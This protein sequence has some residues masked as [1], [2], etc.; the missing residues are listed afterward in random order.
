ML[1]G[2]SGEVIW[3][4]CEL[5]HSGKEMQRGPILNGLPAWYLENQLAKFQAGIR[6]NS[7]ENRSAAL[8]AAA[9]SQIQSQIERTR[10]VQY[11]AQLPRPAQ[12]VT[13]PGN[14]DHGAVVY[15]TCVPC[16]GPNGGG[17]PLKKSPPIH[18]LEDWYMIDQLRKFKAGLRGADLRDQEG[19]LM[20]PVIMP[21]SD[22]DLRDVTRFIATKLAPADII[23]SKAK[24]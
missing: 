6:G 19:F 23:M 10:V 7:M 16:H 8:M 4:A 15:Q 22:Q 9:M 13:V 21:L 12:L 14:A 2:R 20:R 5:C 24:P 17:D 11:I 1:P 18:L 3:Q